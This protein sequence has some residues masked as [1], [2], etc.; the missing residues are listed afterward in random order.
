MTYL[1]DT[2]TWFW[3]LTAPAKLPAKT[4]QLLLHRAHAP[5]GLTAISVWEFA[6]LVQKGRITLTI[7]V[8]EW[9][10]RA[11]DPDLIEVVPLSPAIALESTM[12]PGA[13]HADPADE[14]LAA[15]ARVHNLTLLTADR[16]LR[17]YPHVKTCWD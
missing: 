11:I 2:H 13:F 16:R 3:A 14:L 5:F 15:T 12:L 6:K 9:V 8:R 10:T 4:R 17:A 7:P 1:L